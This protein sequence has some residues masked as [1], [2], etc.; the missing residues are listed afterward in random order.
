MKRII[1]ILLILSLFFPIQVKAVSEATPLIVELAEKPEVEYRSH[2]QDIGWQSYVS[3]GAQSGTTGRNLKIEAMN[4]KLKNSNGINIKY[5]TYIQGNGWQ[6][7]VANGE[8]TGTTGRNLRMEAI[9]IWLEGTEEYSVTYRTHIQDIGW[10]EWKY[11][12][13]I[14]GNLGD[15]K[16]IE[17][18][19]IKIV[20]KEAERISLSYN[21]H[22]QDIGWETEVDEY[23]I[24]G[25]TGQNKKVEAI[26]INLKNAPQGINIKYKTYV[27]KTGWQ[28]W[29]NSGEESGTTGK[30]LKLYGIRI[31]LEG[32]TKYSIQY[33]VHVQDIGWMN[34]VE[35]GAISGKISQNK[36]IE[37]IQVK[38]VEKA[39]L[40]ENDIGVEYYTALQGISSTEDKVFKNGEIAGTTGQNRKIEGINIDLINAPIGSNI[41]Y[42]VHVQDKGWM[43]WIKD[44][45]TAGVLEKGLKIEAIRIRLEGLDEYTVEYRTHV[46]DIGWTGWKIDG[47]IAG[48]TGRNLKIEAIQIKIVPHYEKY[49]TGIDVS[50]WQGEINYDKLFETGEVD[51]M[52][53]RIGWYSRNQSKFIEDIQFKRNYK[54]THSKGIPIGGYVYSYATTVEE[55]K[56]EARETVNYLKSTGQTNF[57][58]PIFFDIEDNTQI[59]LGK[60]KTAEMT[61]A[62]GEIIKQ[63]GFKPGVYSYYYFLFNYMDLSMIPSD[64]EIWV[65]DFGKSNDG[66]LPSDIFKYSKYDMWQYSEKGKID[67]IEGYVDL[68]IRY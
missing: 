13:E 28:E 34:W 53:P 62:F 33:R 46:Q 12:G 58:L 14:S 66:Q 20:T 41:K 59:N 5:S 43:E 7:E 48:T 24:S 50:R 3:E 55:A 25:T 36:K 2:V 31:K 65:A 21:T 49:Q 51:F 39:N 38:I 32:S 10:Q 60:Q 63:A 22:V 4:I 17:A 11:D 44:G 37:A 23:D 52:I 47:E 27:E 8:Q 30:N 42:M 26:K 68:N 18:I 19:E 64:Y 29:K 15:N 61:I 9:K 45:K 56:Q 35:N 67:G 40:S 6:K 54:Q 16:K 57:D 1:Y